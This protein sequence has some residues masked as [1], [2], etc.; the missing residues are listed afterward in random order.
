MNEGSRFALALS[1]GTV[2]TSNIIGGVVLGYLMDRWLLTDPWFI[3]TGLI[4]G[5]ISAFIG[6]FRI[7]NRLNK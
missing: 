7:L 1:V 6:I 3:T 5:A 4:L 2:I